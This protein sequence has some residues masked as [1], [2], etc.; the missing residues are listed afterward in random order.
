M[1]NT[2]A[3]RGRPKRTTPDTRTPEQKRAEYIERRKAKAINAV[4]NFDKL[5]DATRIR[6]PAVEILLG[7]S[8]ATIW[9]RVKQGSLPEPRRD[10]GTTSWSVGQIRLAL[11]G[12]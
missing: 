4:A 3:R 12:A 7:I 5:P 10:G 1:T 9:R 8:H 11:A 6:Q 2:P